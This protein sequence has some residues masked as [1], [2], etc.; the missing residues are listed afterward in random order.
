MANSKKKNQYLREWRKKNR[1][2]YLQKR[3]ENYSKN[4]DKYREKAKE[5]AHH[6]YHNVKKIKNAN[7]P[8]YKQELYEA[9]QRK[10][11]RWNDFLLQLR[12]D[13]G[14]E[15]A[16]C[17]Y[18]KDIR[19]LQFHHTGEIKK[20][21]DVVLTRNRKKAREEAKKCILLCPNC[22]ALHHLENGHA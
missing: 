17:G 9:N 2:T 16:H 11:H 4:K 3:R 20:S 18:K 15:C 7:D 13:C 1:A 10:K 19:I 21:M 14:G 6:W 12:K 5:R 8:N 22:H